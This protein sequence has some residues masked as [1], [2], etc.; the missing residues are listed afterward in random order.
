M[1]Q[2]VEHDHPRAS[3]FLRK[4]CANVN[5][6]FGKTVQHP[7]EPLSLREL[8]DFVT[9]DGAA[10]ATDAEIDAD[11]QA[12]M[13]A[14]RGGDAQDDAVF[15]NAFLPRS[16]NELGFNTERAQRERDGGENEACY[17]AALD[18]LLKA[19]DPA[20]D[21][22]AS[23]GDDEEDDDDEEEAD[24]RGRLPDGAEDR[25][26]AKERKKAAAK[27]QKEARRESRKS[28]VKKHVKKKACKGHKKV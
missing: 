15:M 25:A 8:F 19:E 13:E 11:L 10:F 28:K 26:R 12:R 20:D 23:T 27:A 18:G 1:S 22:D 21:D 14:A 5:D 3:E 9:G 6:F 7:I 17:D 2:S 16:L 24:A 4:D